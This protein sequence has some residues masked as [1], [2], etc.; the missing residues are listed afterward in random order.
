MVHGDTYQDINISMDTLKPLNLMKIMVAHNIHLKIL[1]PIID[2]ST[3]Q[4]NKR[5]CT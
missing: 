4:N 3:T 5:W 1:L 2:L